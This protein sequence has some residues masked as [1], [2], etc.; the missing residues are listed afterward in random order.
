MSNVIRL[1]SVVSLT[2]LSQL[3]H[4][5]VRWFSSG[6]GEFSNI[7]F[8]MDALTIAITAGGCLFILFCWFCN[9]VRRSSVT[10]ERILYSP[11]RLFPYEW[12][13]LRLTTLGLLCG[14]IY[15]QDSMA[16]NLIVAES[17][18]I[19]LLSLQLLAVALLFVSLLGFALYTTVIVL[20]FPM[21]F[22]LELSL[23][24]MFEFLAIAWALALI[25]PAIS[26]FDRILL[27]RFML[28]GEDFRALAVSVLRIGVGI[29]LIVLAVHNKLMDPGLALQFLSEFSYLNFMPALGFESFTNLHFVYSAG[30]AETC[31]GLALLGNFATRLVIFVVGIC[32]FSTS[33]L[34]GIH[35]LVGHLPFLG[36]VVVLLAN[37]CTRQLAE[38]NPAVYK[39]GQSES[40]RRSSLS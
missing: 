11:V 20:M 40:L 1:F 2:L 9:V 30:I 25:S 15:M 3:S 36:V 39:S 17:H 21:F 12:Q 31:F 4:A 27:S 33:V 26:R 10:V 16:P 18:Y 29:Q 7:Y 24:Y 5:H 35:E 13:I 32:F 38:F 37:P 34:M 14:V 22:S 19:I 28:D 23:D 6:E 8:Q